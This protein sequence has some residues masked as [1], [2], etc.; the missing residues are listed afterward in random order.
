MTI[1][2]QMDASCL[3]LTAGEKDRKCTRKLQHRANECHRS[4]KEATCLR[5]RVSRKGLVPCLS[6][7]D[8]QAVEE[9]SGEAEGTRSRETST[10][11]APV[12]G[13]Q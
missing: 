8:L 7:R 9:S 11:E 1:G 5:C 3:E 4:P 2:R 13:Q 10:G 6:A 12:V